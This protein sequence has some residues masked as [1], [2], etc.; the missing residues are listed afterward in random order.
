MSTKLAP[1]GSSLNWNN[2][3]ARH[4]LN[5]GGFGVSEASIARLAGMKP[6][7]AV[8]AL[9]NYERFADNLQ[10]PDFIGPRPN[11]AELREMYGNLSQDERRALYMRNRRDER[12]QMEQLKVWWLQTMLQTT[13]PLQE[14]MALFW[15]GHFATSAKD[16]KSPEFNFELNQVFRQQATGNFKTLVFAVGKTPAML[17]YLNNK[18][19]RK[20]SPNENWARELME[21][22]TMGI[23]S[24]TEEDIKEAARAFT[25]YTERDGEFTFVEQQHDYGEKT[26]LGRTG[27]FDGKDIIDIIHEQPE[28]PRFIARKIWEYLVYES[29][30]DELVEELAE[31]FKS[32]DYELKPLLQTIFLSREFYGERA[33]A[34]Q[35]KSPAQYMV[36]LI[37][38]LSLSVNRGPL[39][40]LAMRGLGQDLFYPPNVKGW[41]G[42]RAWIDTNTLLL[43]YN[44]P[45]YVLT[46]N[47]PNLRRGLEL[48]EAGPDTVKGGNR[49]QRSV[50]ARIMN[51]SPIYQ[52]YE[53]RTVA[54]TVDSLVERYVGRD[55][56][57]EQ[58][59]VLM[60]T[61]AGGGS[62]Q[63]R[64]NKRNFD[65]TRGAAT[66]HLI[67]SLAE[68]QLC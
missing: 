27:N 31:V 68:Y 9:V 10:E 49:A 32:N 65:N 13:R 24:Y 58:R 59:A 46:G 39:V 52:P 66:L 42:N 18:Q 3:T 53:G 40:A 33:M 61:L 8:D 21:L 12:Q 29:P 7:R 63:S 26:F 14:K 45:G 28:T 43:R 47:R 54:E 4:L 17:N 57:A 51:V 22:F 38:Q 55:I 19:N 6:E 2:R 5:R 37:D 44:I 15:H 56:D 62:A 23:G 20:N 60:Q 36:T 50:R 35:I 67:L 41:E 48:D 25:G 16:V 64:L 1:A 30:D 11:F 34:G